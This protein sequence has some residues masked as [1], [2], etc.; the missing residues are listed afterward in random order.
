M[1]DH[2]DEPQAK[3]FKVRIFSVSIPTFSLKRGPLASILQPG[4]EGGPSAFS[5]QPN[6]V[7]P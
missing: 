2:Y 4:V 6:P 1:D 3:R 5:L 7:R